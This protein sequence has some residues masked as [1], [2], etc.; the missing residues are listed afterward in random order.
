MT[1]SALFRKKIKLKK[2]GEGS[3][4]DVVINPLK[5]SKGGIK[6]KRTSLTRGEGKR[7]SSVQKKES[8]YGLDV[9]F[10]R[11]IGKEDVIQVIPQFGVSFL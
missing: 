5:V 11:Q 7:R 8:I 2:A 10:L 9:E 1:S 3:P 4:N 6:F